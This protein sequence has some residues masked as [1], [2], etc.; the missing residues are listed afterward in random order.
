ML[1]YTQSVRM[2]QFA[3]I[4]QKSDTVCLLKTWK[5]LQDH[6]TCCHEILSVSTEGEW[7]FPSEDNIEAL[8]SDL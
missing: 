6:A 5:L 3:V 1:Y 7:L 8:V 4:F 2:R